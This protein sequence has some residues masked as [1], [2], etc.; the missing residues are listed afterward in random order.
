MAMEEGQDTELEGGSE[1]ISQL[2]VS[3]NTN[4]KYLTSLTKCSTIQE[5]MRLA[6]VYRDILDLVPGFRDQ[7][8]S[9]GAD[10]SALNK[11]IEVVRKSI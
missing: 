5:R 6:R 8:D 7:I 9:L 1:F 3:M 10:P 4:R 2:S 11:V